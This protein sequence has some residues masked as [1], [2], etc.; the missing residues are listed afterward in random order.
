MITVRAAIG[1]DVAAIR[2]I[3]LHIYKNLAVGMGQKL[4]R[5]DVSL[6]DR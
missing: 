3:G 2:D 6:A 1:R 5:L 4:K